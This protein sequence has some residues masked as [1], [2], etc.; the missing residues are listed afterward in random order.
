MQ[1]PTLEP[2]MNAPTP[3]ERGRIISSNEISIRW[4]TRNQALAE[5]IKHLARKCK[6]R[7]C[8]TIQCSCHCASVSCTELCCC[9]NCN[10]TPITSIKNELLNEVT[11]AED[12]ENEA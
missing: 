12:E 7:H 6:R 4:V 11:D 10:N 8:N 9:V 5:L 3:Q 1:I 2:F